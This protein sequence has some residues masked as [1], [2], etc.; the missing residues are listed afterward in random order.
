M[1]GKA[2]NTMEGLGKGTIII[3]PTFMNPSCTFYIH[4]KYILGDLNAIKVIT[5]IFV[6]RSLISALLRLTTSI[7]VALCRV[8]FIIS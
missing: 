1:D 6:E 7:V 5:L 4:R 2:E 3:H 8:I